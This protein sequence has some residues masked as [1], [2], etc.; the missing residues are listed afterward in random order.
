MYG[1][2]GSRIPWVTL[3]R[4]ELPVISAF[5]ISA[6]LYFKK[7]LKQLILNIKILNPQHSQ[8]ENLKEKKLKLTQVKEAVEKGA[9]VDAADA[10]GPG[11]YFPSAI[12]SISGELKEPDIRWMRYDKMNMFT[13]FP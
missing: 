7:Q 9:D 3:W 2:D 6:F 1:A 10:Y 11:P 8:A 4:P 12:C 5:E 13:I